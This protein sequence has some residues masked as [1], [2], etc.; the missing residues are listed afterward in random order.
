MFLSK[1]L[2]RSCMIKHYTKEEKVFVAIAYRL[3]HSRNIKKSC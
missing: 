2:T 1:I 3:L